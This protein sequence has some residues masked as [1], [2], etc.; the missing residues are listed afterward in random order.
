MNRQTIQGTTM[1]NKSQFHYCVIHIH[2][3]EN[4]SDSRRFEDINIVYSTINKEEAYVK[5]AEKWLGMYEEFL[6]QN[7]GNGYSNYSLPSDHSNYNEICELLNN[8][9][10]AEDLHNYFAN[11]DEIWFSSDINGV[12]DEVQILDLE[13]KKEEI[14]TY[15]MNS[16]LALQDR[17]IKEKEEAEKLALMRTEA[18]E[19][20]DTCHFTHSWL[21][22]GNPDDRRSEKEEVASFDFISIVIKILELI[23]EGNASLNMT[24]GETIEVDF[25]EGRIEVGPINI[26]GTDGVKLYIDKNIFL[27]NSS[28]KVSQKVLALI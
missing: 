12:T 11:N 2:R 25:T 14:N 15:N 20:G 3:W 9:I 23:D 16:L 28:W 22:F 10:P 7:I 26:Y 24:E 4:F 19:S 17:V 5:A 8:D 21:A 6:C 13:F 27:S 18:F 1:T